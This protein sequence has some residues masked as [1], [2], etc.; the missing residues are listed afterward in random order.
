[1][2]DLE[3]TLQGNDLGFMRI[4]AEAWGIELN[5]PD[6]YK[7][8]PELSEAIQ[9]HQLAG[10][11]IETLPETARQ[12]L[13]H[14]LEHEGRVPWSQFCRRF[15]E[16]RTMGSGRRDRER[17]DRQPISA[18]EILWYRVLIGRA[19]LGQHPE[20]QEYAYIPDEFLDYLEPLAA[21]SLITMGRAATPLECSYLLP[22]SDRIQDH[23]CTI[24]AARRAELRLNTLN[25]ESWHIP[26]DALNRLLV[27][28]GLLDGRGKPKPEIVRSFL[29]SGRA[30]SLAFLVKNW[31]RSSTFNELRLLPGLNFEGEWQNNPLRARQAILKMLSEVPLDTWWNLGSFVAAVKEHRPDFQRP[32][33]DYDSWFIRR[34]V[35][36]TYLR[37]FSSWDEVDGALVRFMITDPLHWM[38]LYDLAASSPDGAP[39]SFRP[40]C[41]AESLW[42]GSP[43]GGL[44]DENV[45]IRLTPDGRLR[46]SALTARAVRYQ[47]A[48]FCQWEGEQPGKEAPGQIDDAKSYQRALKAITYHFFLTPESMKRAGTQGL[49]QSHL[50]SL[51]RRHSKDALPP[52]LLQ[53]LESWETHG[54][55]ASIEQPV[56]LRVESPEVLKALQETKAARFL[57]EMLNATTVIIK[58]GSEERVR[59][60]LADLGCLTEVS[61]DR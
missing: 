13:R 52:G 47:V 26:V 29:E 14:L 1:M 36:N 49:R 15:G 50:V 57:G 54:V 27:T 23:A 21:E 30:E 59:R 34:A 41:L 56:L 60:A 39:V 7:A 20:T 22:A 42:H 10:E 55:Q 35:D 11:V 44:P 9:D 51:L 8:L 16:V 53:A 45:P 24:L 5:A 18:A 37:G 32:A 25:T 2:P 33:G 58:P 38:G 40:S 61:T 17:P 48:R 12:A 3:H 19:F 28:V 4:V 31:M 46:L 43:P 6:A